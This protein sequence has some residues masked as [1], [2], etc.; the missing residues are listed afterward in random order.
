MISNLKNTFNAGPIGIAPVST[1][2]QSEGL[3]TG[4]GNEFVYCSGLITKRDKSIGSIVLI[5]YRTGKIG[6]VST[7]DGG[8]TWSEWFI[9]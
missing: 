8:E 6:I 1:G 5:S 2:E 9:K 7:S 4:Y 3:P